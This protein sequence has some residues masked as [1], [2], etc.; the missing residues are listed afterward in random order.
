M[1]KKIF[2]QGQI[3]YLARIKPV[4]YWAAWIAPLSIFFMYGEHGEFAKIGWIALVAVMAIRPLADILPGLRIL[5]TLSCLRREFGVFA[6]MMFIAHFVGWMLYRG[7]TLPEIFTKSYFW[8][9]DG[10]FLWGLLG[11]FVTILVLLTSNLFAMKF[12][13]RKWNVMQDLS[14]LILLFGGIHIMLVG[15]KSGLI[16][17]AIVTILCLLAKLKF[18]LKLIQ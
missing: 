10:I 18:R 8:V 12:L 4:L 16:G 5:R 7:I 14:Y 2:L 6:G 1:I 13:K 11:I 15:E 9:P 3:P 17:I